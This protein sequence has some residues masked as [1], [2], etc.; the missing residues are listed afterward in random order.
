MKRLL[1]TALVLG[2]PLLGGCV[3]AAI[4]VGAALTAQEFMDN[5]TLAF[6]EEDTDEVWKAAR[7]ALERASLDP[8]DVD[9]EARGVRA[10]IDGATVTVHVRRFDTSQTRLA[11]TARKWGFYDADEASRIITLIKRELAR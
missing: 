8:L 2:A 11:V 1:A 6:L 3:A 5:A 9:E 10:N 7:E 4:G